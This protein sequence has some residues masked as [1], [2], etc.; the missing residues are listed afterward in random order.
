MIKIEVQSTRAVIRSQEP[1]T[2]G[3]Q[4]AKVQFSFGQDWKDLTKTA[5]FRQGEVVRTVAN[6]GQEATIP[7]EVL[8]VPGVPVQIGIYGIGQG[9]AIPTLWTTTQPVRPGADPQGDP[10]KEPTP[11]LWEQMQ[12]QLRAMEEAVTEVQEQPRS[13]IVTVVQQPDGT[14]IA[15]CDPE[16]IKQAV[17]D[18]WI[19]G[20]YWYDKD[21]MLSLS[22]FQPMGP[23]TF[24]AVYDATE[25]HVLIS[26][27]GVVTCSEIDLWDSSVKVTVTEQSD[28]TYTADLSHE[29]LLEAYN[30]GKILFCLYHGKIMPLVVA[31]KAQM[32]FGCVYTGHI[33][34]VTVGVSRVTVTATPLAS[35][36]A[37]VLYTPQTLTLEQQAQARQNIGLDDLPTGGSVDG[38]VLINELILEADVNGVTFT[39]DSDGNPLS[40]AGECFLE[41]INPIAERCDSYTI[42]TG[43][44]GT[45]G[46]RSMAASL[47][48]A[49][50]ITKACLDIR[51][52]AG[53]IRFLTGSNS[54]SHY[55]AQVYGSTQLH[56]IGD[57]TSITIRC[58]IG[59]PL[60]TGCVCRLYA[61]G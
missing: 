59:T 32:V 28:G 1:L 31:S 55:I 34:T 56:D 49:E 43:T 33:Y 58:A 36:E 6:V 48:N 11:G 3:L 38:Y 4:G 5:V 16:Q 27:S 60:M 14:Y 10:S 41:I 39:Q 22:A 51:R 29:Q 12:S 24:T 52:I 46:Q 7:W 26:Q 17:E 50:R 57:I 13:L 2:V 44:K 25:Y 40:I 47:S 9:K 35:P 19:L 23:Y 45:T 30:N 42:I 61:R 18:Q 54:S 15:D 53:K 20:C 8:T 21:M 37:S